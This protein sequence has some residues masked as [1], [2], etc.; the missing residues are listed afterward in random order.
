MNK[1]RISSLHSLSSQEGLIPSRGKKV[2]YQFV[3]AESQGILLLSLHGGPA[4]VPI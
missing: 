2:W 1:N 3:G 4:V